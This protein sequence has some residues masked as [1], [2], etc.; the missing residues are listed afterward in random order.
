MFDLLSPKDAALLVTG[1]VTFK[2][3]LKSSES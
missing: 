2:K 1:F 3:L